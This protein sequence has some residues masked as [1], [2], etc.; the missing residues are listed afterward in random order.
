MKI[1]VGDLTLKQLHDICCLPCE[2]CPLNC[3]HNDHNS[4]M[5]KYPEYDD[6]EVEILN[7]YLTE[8]MKRQ[9]SET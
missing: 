1:K 2:E 6:T 3:G 5:T 8:T 7:E 4:C 9:T